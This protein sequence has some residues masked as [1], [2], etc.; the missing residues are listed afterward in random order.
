MTDKFPE[1]KYN[2]NYGINS[3][4]KIFLCNR[5]PMFKLIEEAVAEIP[6]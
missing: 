3:E 6:I 1:L 2:I 4:K 5:P